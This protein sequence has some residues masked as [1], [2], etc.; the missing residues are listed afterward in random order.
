VFCR[1][2]CR[3]AAHL[4]RKLGAAEGLGPDDVIVGRQDLEDLL[5]ELY[6]L[7][8]A[9]EDV[10]RDLAVSSKATDVREAFDWLYRNAKPLCDRWLEPRAAEPV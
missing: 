9:V 8:S 2:A 1:P 3:Q 4:A 7:Q 10:E 6:C 5:G